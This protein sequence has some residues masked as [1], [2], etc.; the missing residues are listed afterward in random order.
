[1]KSSTTNVRIANQ[2][3][4]NLLRQENYYKNIMLKFTLFKS[5]QENLRIHNVNM[6]SYKLIWIFKN[7][8]NIRVGNY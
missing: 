5:K 7:N 2:C 3:Y 6:V 8:Y 1:M 4:A